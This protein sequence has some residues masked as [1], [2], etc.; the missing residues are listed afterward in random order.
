MEGASMRRWTLDFDVP[1]YRENGGFIE[2]PDG[3]WVRIADVRTLL[4]TLALIQNSTG[5]ADAQQVATAEVGKPE[6]S[7]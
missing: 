2:D 5:L 6:R 4:L 7:T 3:E 1:D